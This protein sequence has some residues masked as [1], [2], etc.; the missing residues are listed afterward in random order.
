M[1]YFM[2]LLKEKKLSPKKLYDKCN[3]DSSD[4]IDLNEIK[5][6]IQEIDENIHV[7][8]LKAIYTF[9]DI[10]NDGK[11]TETEFINKLNEAAGI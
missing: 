11:V 10:N 2:R 8:Q 6:L 4:C 3:T 7:K 5:K 9:L 1:V